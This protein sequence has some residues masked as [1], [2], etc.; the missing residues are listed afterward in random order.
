[1][2]P[3]DEEDTFAS[4]RYRLW[5]TTQNRWGRFPALI[6]QSD[7]HV[8]STIPAFEANRRWMNVGPIAEGQPKDTKTTRIAT[9]SYDYLPRQL[10]EQR[11]QHK[12]LL[13][14]DGWGWSA[15]FRELLRAD[16][17]VIK[18]TVFREYSTSVTPS[19]L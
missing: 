17:A 2:Y 4:Q 14:V 18:T 6:A 12:A 8:M 16:G 3:S 7:Q 10:V 1:M 5:A 11:N 19:P 13:D 9:A 15:R